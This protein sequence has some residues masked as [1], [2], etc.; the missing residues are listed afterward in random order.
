MHA[1]LHSPHHAAVTEPGLRHGGRLLGIGALLAGLTALP[2]H[3]QGGPDP[4]VA[5]AGGAGI[6]YLVQKNETLSA[7]ARRFTG[8]PSDWQKIGRLNRVADDRRIPIGTRILIPSAL[9]PAGPA[10]AKILALSGDIAV[11]RK[12]GPGIAPKAGDILEEGDMLST[13]ANGFVSLGLDDG[14]RLTLQPGSRAMLRVLRTKRHAGRPKTQVYLE[15]G[16]IESHVAP[17]PDRGHSSYEVVSPVAVSSV[18]G[19]AFR[20]SVGE[21]RA[22]NEV[23]EG[24]VAV[25]GNAGKTPR[26][27]GKGFGAIVEDGRVGAP[28][29]LLAAPALRDG[30]QSQQKLPLQFALDSPGAVGFHV[31]IGR[32]RDGADIVQAADVEGDG[33]AVAKFADLPDGTYVVRYRAIDARGLQG[34]EGESSFK[35]KARPFPPLLLQRRD[36]IQAE[37]PGKEAAVTL[38]WAQQQDVCGY[39]LQLAT[40][41]GFAV[42]DLDQSI[43]GN[44]GRYALHLQP[45]VYDWRVASIASTNGKPDQG[46]FGDARRLEIVAGQASPEVA[47][48]DGEARFS[49]SGSADQVFTFELSDSPSFDKVLVTMEVDKPFASLPDLAPGVYYARVRGIDSDGFIG[50]FSP[51]QRFAVPLRWKSAYGDT[52]QA[53]TQPAGT[54]AG[55]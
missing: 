4:S 43:A 35:L 11:R 38:E 23:V 14:T 29:A 22:L 16:R 37:Q 51:P 41:R 52:W 1:Y 6:L 17:A 42:P 32:D 45:G 10:T 25:L 2:A 39:R 44:V 26:M 54:G 15:S 50:T 27:V 33:H 31:A 30:Y 18:R 34:W 9:L 47:L 3:A 46:P 8:K 55:D 20:V 28:L 53:G 12:N 13:S 49:W 40:D 5:Q 36:K 48:S 7:I 21:R 24:T 19:T